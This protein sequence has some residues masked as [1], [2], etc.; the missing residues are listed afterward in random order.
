M[1]FPAPHPE[2]IGLPVIETDRL[3]L[4]GPQASDWPMFRDFTMSNRATFV[5]GPKNEAETAQKFAGFFG[6]WVMRGFGRLI[7]VDRTTGSPVGHFGPMQWIDN[8]EIELTWSLWTADAEGKGFATEAAKAMK[9]WVFPA[10]S[11]KTARAEVHQNNPASSRIALALGGK[12]RDGEK[13]TWFDA[14]HVY[15]FTAGA[16]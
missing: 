6:H 15:G 3:V 10:L 13:P 11:I 9:A 4:R 14:G 16:A 1:S 7:A 8:A 12:L 2:L 5:G